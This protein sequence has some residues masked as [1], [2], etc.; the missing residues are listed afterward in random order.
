M[1]PVLSALPLEWADAERP[2][3]RADEAR[4]IMRDRDEEDWPAVVLA[5]SLTQAGS[6]AIWTQDTDMAVSKLP[7]IT[8]GCAR[9]A[10]GWP[11]ASIRFDGPT[12]GLT[13]VLGPQMAAPGG[14]EEGRIV[15]RT[16][17]SGPLRTAP[18]RVRKPLL[19]PLSYGGK[20]AQGSRGLFEER[21][22]A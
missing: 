1:L 7:I 11:L 15:L 14:T 12:D 8:T 3:K 20:G 22:A 4:E 18:S 2:S 16:A 5:L 10:R 13:R 9:P 17:L 6:V 19:Y 21:L